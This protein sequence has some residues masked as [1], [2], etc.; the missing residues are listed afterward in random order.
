MR[1]AEIDDFTMMLLLLVGSLLLGIVATVIFRSTVPA[2]IARMFRIEDAEAS[3][4]SRMGA[5]IGV[6][7]RVRALQNEL[8][9]AK[10]GHTMLDT[11]QR[12]LRRQIAV[13]N[14]AAPEL[15][16]EVGEAR[17]GLN[18]YLA[19]LTVESTSPFLRPSSDLYNPMWRQVN[20]AEVWAQ[21]R[22]E[23]RQQLDLA[24]SDKLG[25]MKVMVDSQAGRG[26]GGNQ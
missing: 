22:D 9:Q 23:A 16:H 15:I 24:F 17:A 20:M 12:K 19:R 5:A 3:F 13:A 2:L 26:P 6:R 7:D 25:Y 18:R 1:V 10:G 11:D 21:T 4:N 14:N 8:S